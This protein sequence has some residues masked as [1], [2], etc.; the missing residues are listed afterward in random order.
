MVADITFYGEKHLNKNLYVDFGYMDFVVPRSVYT[1]LETYVYENVGRH[2]LKNKY[3]KFACEK[4]SKLSPPD[5]SFKLKDDSAI[6]TLTGNDYVMEDHKGRFCFLGLVPGKGDDW[7]IG[8]LFFRKYVTGMMVTS[9]ENS[10]KFGFLQ[11]KR[12]STISGIKLHNDMH[13]EPLFELRAA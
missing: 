6:Y 5:I 2:H 12:V 13:H 11:V 8:G 1:K 7:T 10:I 3:I 9:S 4:R